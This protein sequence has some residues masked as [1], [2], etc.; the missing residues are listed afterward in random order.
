M[1][2]HLFENI[3][4]GERFG[5]VALHLDEHLVRGFA[6]AV[7]DF[8]ARFF[9]SAARC[10]PFVAPALLAKKLLHI[11]MLKYDPQ[12]VSAIHLKDDIEFIA[13][14]RFGDEVVLSA[15]YSDTFVRKSRTCVVLDG[16]ARGPDG[17]LLLRHR[18]IE[19]VPARSSHP[20]RA[21]ADPVGLSQRRVD[22]SWPERAEVAVNPTVARVGMVLPA[23]CR[24]IH[25]DQMSVFVGANEG[26]RNIHTDLEVARAAGF[27]ST[28]MSGMIQACWFTHMVTDFLG[29]SFLRGGRLG[30]TFLRNVASGGTVQLRAVIRSVGDDGAF[31]I[32][33]W[34]ENEEGVITA[35][36]WAIGKT[37]T[38]NCLTGLS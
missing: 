6:F 17:A 7:D 29:D 34:S 30:I 31:E 26:W 5:P 1:K 27:E 28:I 19:I 2:Q 13:P 8:S 21:Q 35:V 16:E 23:R 36:G 37:D 4:R 18:S 15:C 25:Q 32:E 33:F 22:A 14:A 24:T 9:A 38:T 20:E 3:E 11:F 10:G 12:G